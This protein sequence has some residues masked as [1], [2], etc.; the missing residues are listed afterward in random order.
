MRTN[1]LGSTANRKLPVTSAT[2]RRLTLTRRV[3]RQEEVGLRADPALPVRRQP[4]AGDDAMQVGMEEQV[5]PPG[6]QQRRDADLGAE[7][8]GVR[9]QGEQGRRGGPEEQVVEPPLVAQ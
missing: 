3:D 8:L 9:G 2:P 4:A 1:P 7:S 5:L 6:V